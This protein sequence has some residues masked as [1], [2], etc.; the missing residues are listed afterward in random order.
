LFKIIALPIF[1]IVGLA[2]LLFKLLT[3]LSS[4][5]IGPLMFFIIGCDIW[6][7]IGQKWT[8]CLILTGLAAVC[9]LVLFAA[10]FVIVLLENAREG[11]S[12]YIRS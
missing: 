1:L 9:F 12:G 11:I 8:Q 10:A 6:C 4:Y 3:N 7:L 2:E 5:V